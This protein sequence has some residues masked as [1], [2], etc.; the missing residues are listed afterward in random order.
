MGEKEGRDSSQER[1]TERRRA[2]GE[3]LQSIVR[4]A[5]ARVEEDG[6]ELPPV[7]KPRVVLGETS[8]MDDRKELVLVAPNGGGEELIITT[9]TNTFEGDRPP[10][11]MVGIISCYKTLSTGGSEGIEIYRL[12]ASTEI[13][14][15]GGEQAWHDS[16][17]QASAIM[18][19]YTMGVT[20]KV[21]EHLPKT[22]GEWPVRPE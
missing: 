21:A 11:E 7:E 8:P 15:M 20:S 17:M 12:Q 10:V 1:Y 18:N 2:Y 5:Q 6:K 9:W 4:A 13:L 14:E 16:M 19:P 3:A 22:I